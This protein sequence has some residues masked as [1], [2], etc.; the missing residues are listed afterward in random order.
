MRALPVV[1]LVAYL[2]A[3]IYTLV[4]Q[5]LALP[6]PLSLFM[7]Y[8]FYS[9]ALAR[10]LSGADMYAV[11]RIGS[12]F[13]YPPPALLF[14]DLLNF[15]PD[16]IA[17]GAL[18]AALDVLMATTLVYWLGRRYSL[19]PERSALLLA[20]SLA[21]APFLV[22]L[23]LGQVNM[24]TQFGLGILFVFALSVPWLAGLGLALAIV[25]KLTPLYFMA[26]LLATKNFKVLLWTVLALA[27]FVLLALAR[28]GLQPFFTYV[29]VFRGMTA[30]LP[31]G[32]NGQSL[33]AR[34]FAVGVSPNLGIIQF[35]LVLYLVLATL[36]SAYQT[37]RGKQPEAAFIVTMLAMLLSPNILWYHHYVF[38]ILPLLIWMAWRQNSRAV[39]FWC[40]AGMFLIQLDYFLLSGGL[41]IHIFGHLSI[42][43]VLT[44]PAVSIKSQN[45]A[46]L[47]LQ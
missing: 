27:G 42:L 28:Y 19:Q 16:G 23:Q 7:D 22:T 25:T 13:L 17:R 35:G 9:D 38:F 12:A 14:V 46:L 2:A 37:L 20:V 3:G 6:F 30:V 41:L 5:V 29:E 44:Q 34:L 47:N 39:T 18:L 40:L 21:F 32:E 8:G 43:V 15:L 1:F 24:L 33:L 36:L 45:L 31:V 26:Y 11:R 4:R 10:V